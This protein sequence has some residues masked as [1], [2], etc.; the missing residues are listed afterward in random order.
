MS[1]GRR[2]SVPA[3][4]PPSPVQLEVEV[5]VEADDNDELEVE[6][7]L[8]AGELAAG[9]VD[10][11]REEVPVASG[12]GTTSSRRQS[13][14]PPRRAKTKA[15]A[16]PLL[17]PKPTLVKKRPVQEVEEE[18]VDD[19]DEV[20]PR[21]P[22]KKRSK[23]SPSKQVRVVVSPAPSSPSAASVANSAS[24]DSGSDDS[25]GDGAKIKKK[26]GTKIRS[27][28]VKKNKGKLNA[29]DV[30][31]GR[32]R[33][34]LKTKIE[35]STSTK[36]TKG[37]ER[38]SSLVQVAL[39][40]H[41]DQLSTLSHRTTQVNSARSAAKQLRADL[42]GVQRARAG[43]GRLLAEE[44]AAW[45]TS[46]KRVDLTR[47]LHSFMNDLSSA[48]LDLADP[49]VAAGVP[50]E[51]IEPRFKRLAGVFGVGGEGKRRLLGRIDRLNTELERV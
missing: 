40:S 24:D 3:P 28:R 46:R 38:F 23:P 2:K 7:E 14:L 30:A 48:A 39:L 32:I 29:I 41:S 19:T 10:V 49:S 31:Y 27:E 21:A 17:P 16:K 42:L 50:P 51:G 26:K 12:S 37:L 13:V 36:T 34:I 22:A 9:E 35:N 43:V 18:E 8:A 1:T 5:E 15:A 33:R 4:A 45:N 25:D 6:E 47:R 11:A 20:R 44:E